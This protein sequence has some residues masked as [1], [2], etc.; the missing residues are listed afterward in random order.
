MGIEILLHKNLSLMTTK[1]LLLKHQIISTLI[2]KS[3][4][5]KTQSH[6]IILSQQIDVD[7]KILN[8]LKRR[9]IKVDKKQRTVDLGLKPFQIKN[10]YISVTGSV[11]HESPHDLDFI[12][13]TPLPFTVDETAK[14]TISK[15]NKLLPSYS[16]WSNGYYTTP[17][18]T[19]IAI[20]NLTLLPKTKLTTR[21]FA[22]MYS[23]K[24]GGKN[25]TIPLKQ[26]LDSLPQELL[27]MKDLIYYLPYQNTFYVKKILPL[28][29]IPIYIRL[30]RMFPPKK[31]PK[32][33]TST[34]PNEAIPVYDLK[35]VKRK[36]EKIEM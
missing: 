26:I 17:F 28:Y 30:T 18:S 9:E 12:I 14:K 20:Y 19:F 25:L 4:S 3:Q 36:L 31:Q 13:Y 15:L 29:Y 33:F 16:H 5:K 11:F 34:I 2:K 27:I 32:I 35:L 1:E 8:E 7:N 24:D 22:P 10:P 6:K 21:K 23:K